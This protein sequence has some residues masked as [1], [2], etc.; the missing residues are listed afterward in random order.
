MLARPV[1]G[2][3]WDNANARGA[4]AASEAPAPSDEVRLLRTGRDGRFAFPFTGGGFW[5]TNEWSLVPFLPGA[6]A[7]VDGEWLR[8]A[9]ASPLP[10]AKPVALNGK[11]EFAP[12]AMRELIVGSDGVTLD[13]HARYVAAVAAQAAGLRDAD[14]AALVRR[15]AN[16]TVA[17][18]A[19]LHAD[20][21]IADA[22]SAKLAEW[23]AT[24]VDYAAVLDA[25]RKA[26]PGSGIKGAWLCSAMAN[27]PA[28]GARLATSPT[29]AYVREPDR[30]GGLTAVTPLPQSL[31]DFPTAVVPVPAGSARGPRGAVVEGGA[32]AGPRMVAIDVGP[33]A[34]SSSVRLPSMSVGTIEYGPDRAQ[35][36]VWIDGVKLGVGEALGNGVRVTAI[37]DP[38]GA[39]IEYRGQRFRVSG[40]RR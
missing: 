17:V 21:P 40:Q 9:S 30:R 4:W 35:R 20:E 5:R 1:N 15:T 31:A 8:Q 3:K 19:C 23:V 16:G 2:A 25:Q 18:D 29:G 34:S 28:G 37:P 24:N 32:A 36:A 33:V 22:T 26:Q 27:M 12:I 38:D 10:S 39:E 14:A 6:V 13:A 11:D 7:K